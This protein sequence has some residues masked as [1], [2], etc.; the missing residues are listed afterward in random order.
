MFV[1]AALPFL[2]TV[3]NGFV[4]DD[5]VYVTHNSLLPRGGGWRRSGRRRDLVRST[6][7]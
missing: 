4:W 1:V 6:I 7:R 2:G 5:D 3:G